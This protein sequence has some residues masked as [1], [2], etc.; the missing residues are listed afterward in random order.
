MPKNFSRT[1]RMSDLIHRT[2]ARII[3]EEF[4]D[5]RV[6]MITVSEVEV[7]ADLKYAKV[8]I[9]V[10]EEA[11][12][13]ETLKVLNQASGFFRSHLARLLKCR[14]TPKPEF[15]FDDSVIRGIRI[16]SILESEGG[17][18]NVE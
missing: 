8:Y 17:E 6:G 15:V 11:K 5:P 9:T 3:R 14:V 4:K 16:T 10:L 1:H 2:L 13:E 7:S 18:S 12:I